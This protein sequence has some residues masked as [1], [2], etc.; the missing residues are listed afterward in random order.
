MS[1]CGLAQ[2]NEWECVVCACSHFVLPPMLVS[3]EQTLPA[4]PSLQ[5][6]K[7][8]GSGMEAGQRWLE[9]EGSQ[10]SAENEADLRLPPLPPQ[11]SIS[12]SGTPHKRD[13]FIYSTW[14]E[15]SVST[16][17][18]GSSPGTR[19]G[20]AAPHTGLSYGRTGAGVGTEG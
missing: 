9:G 19:P 7:G 4:P 11:E 12:S 15:D 14:L 16:T 2:E 20:A 13:S 8:G 1:L 3:L 6:G 17:S 18:G 5:G 10:A